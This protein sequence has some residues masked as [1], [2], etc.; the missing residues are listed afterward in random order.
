MIIKLKCSVSACPLGIGSDSALIFYITPKIYLFLQRI[1]YFL[2]FHL[3]FLFRVRGLT[4]SIAA[5]DDAKTTAR[6]TL[7][8]IAGGAT[9]GG[10][11]AAI[12]YGAVLEVIHLHR[13]PEFFNPYP[14]YPELLILTV[15]YTVF[16]REFPSF[17]P[18]FSFYIER[19]GLGGHDLFPTDHHL[20]DIKA[21]EHTKIYHW[22]MEHR[23]CQ[24][25]LIIKNMTLIHILKDRTEVQR[26][27]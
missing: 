3:H 8:G 20:K 13:F 4:S 9:I 25:E 21:D 18:A 19:V 10:I 22:K 17:R 14:F 27:L 23:N 24:K 1:L 7:K 6:N 16:L 5:G 2:F 15:Q 26:G 11:A 12:G